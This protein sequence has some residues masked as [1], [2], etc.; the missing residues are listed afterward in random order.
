MAQY[1]AKIRPPTPRRKRLNVIKAASF[2][3]M[4]RKGKVVKFCRKLFVDRLVRGY[5]LILPGQVQSTLL[6]WTSDKSRGGPSLFLD[7]TDAGRAE[8]IF[9]RPPS[10]Y[11]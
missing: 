9:L 4:H 8:K 7:Q 6:L 1:Q 10:P 5:P 2:R 3:V 11:L